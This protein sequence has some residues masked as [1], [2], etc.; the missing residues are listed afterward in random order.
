MAKLTPH[1][2]ALG[3]WGER[4]AEEHLLDKGYTVLERNVRTPYGEIDLVVE[5]GGVLVFVEVKARSSANFGF[6]ENGLT[7]EKRTHLLNAIQSYLQEHPEVT[8]DWRVDVIAIQRLKGNPV[9]ELV[10]FENA[11]G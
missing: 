1:N 11:L 9:P 6:P 3:R 8:N 7:L 4:L 10:H 5:T 2:Q